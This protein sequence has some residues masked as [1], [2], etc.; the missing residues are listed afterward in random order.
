MGIRHS[1]YMGG[2]GIGDEMRVTAADNARTMFVERLLVTPAGVRLT[3]ISKNGTLVCDEARL[4]R[5]SQRDSNANLYRLATDGVQL[6]IN[7]GDRIQ[8]TTKDAPTE[9]RAAFIGWVDERP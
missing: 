4:S 7:R 8:V 6:A 9:W 5:L 1:F 3:A 2:P